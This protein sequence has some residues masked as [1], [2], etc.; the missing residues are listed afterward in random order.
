[1]RI[2][3]AG[4][5][6][7]GKTT[8]CRRVAARTGLPHTEL[9]SLQHGPDWEPRPQFLNDVARLV[10]EPAWVTEWQYRHARPL[11][12]AR[13]D[14][15]VWLDPPYPVAFWR[16]LRRTLRRR[17]HR[18]VLWNGNVEGPLWRVFVDRD[19]LL[20]WSWRTRAKIPAQL[21]DAR[22]ERPDVRVVRLRT[23]ADVDAWLASLPAR[24]P[25]T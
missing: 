9:D 3:I 12:T 6:G 23:A 15:L 4:V 11:I 10:A 20:R 14:V 16:V 24:S 1:M 18:E 8:L 21:D 17:W 13:A 22:R 19:H 7:S 2:A 25:G 5:T